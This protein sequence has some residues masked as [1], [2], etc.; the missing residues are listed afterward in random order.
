MSEM[1]LE[2]KYLEEKLFNLDK[3]LEQGKI[4]T[5]EY[6]QT[7]LLVKIWVELMDMRRHE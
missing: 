7:C 1:N 6:V 5:V 2:T 4:T 3:A